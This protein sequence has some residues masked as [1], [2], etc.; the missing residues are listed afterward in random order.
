MVGCLFC[1]RES[2]DGC[3]PS[4][5]RMSRGQKFSRLLQYLEKC[6]QGDFYLDVLHCAVDRIKMM[7]VFMMPL[8]FFPKDSFDQR[9]HVI[10]IV[11]R[12]YLE[13][14]SVDVRHLIPADVSGDGNCLY[15]SVLLLT[16]NSVMTTSELRV[17]TIV[18]LITNET[19]YSSMFASVIG[20][21]D[22]AIKVVCKNNTYS[23]LYEISALC[24]VV[25]CNIRSVYP[26]I[27][28]RADMAIM[29]SVF[30]PIPPTIGKYE[31]KILW[32]NVRREAILRSMNNNYWSPNHFV[33][34][35]SPSIR[36]EYAGGSQ[37]K[38]INKVSDKL[39]CADLNCR[40]VY[41]YFS[42]TP[43]KKTTKNNHNSHVRI[44]E[45]QCSPSR[46]LRSET[47]TNSDHV[48]I[49]NLDTMKQ[50]EME[51]EDQHQ[52]RLITLKDRAR[53]RRSSETDAQRQNRLRR[54]RERA[55]SR[56]ANETQEQRQGRLEQKKE[57]ARAARVDESE[58]EHQSRLEQK[59]EYARTARM[60]ESEEERRSRLEQKK[61]Y[62]RTSRVNETA[63]E[64]QIRI[65]RQRERS[66]SNRTNKKLDELAID[67]TFVHQQGIHDH[68]YGN[69]GYI[70]PAHNSKNGIERHDSATNRNKIKDSLTWPAPVSSELK[71][72][73]LK[74]FLQ[75]M[76]MDKLAEVT[77][78]VCN[79]RSS[80]Q[81]CKIVPTSTISHKDL[82]K[83]SNELKG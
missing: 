80:K 30:K 40:Y 81:Q 34:L 25:S 10:D 57:Y 53:L 21:F 67:N 63:E 48:Q 12:E 79:V 68:A 7:D 18:E 75:Q 44:P 74:Q 35:M 41:F 4:C 33:P 31:I 59:K 72:E 13:K 56:R 49:I 14:A 3:C 52:M 9:I 54:D 22:I 83:V 38:L 64:Y 28:F 17:R 61:E 45:F 62:A 82:L 23:E 15:H 77:C 26:E 27:D 29:N 36:H 43:E 55:R 70:Y 11:A 19:Y 8:D 47:S 24:T 2:T 16:N 37:M 66:Q 1:E 78:A 60:N 71:E 58:E 69:N 50:N 6:T 20:P 42:Q 32:S 65:D 73:C 5:D 76:S 51:R 46:R 39:A